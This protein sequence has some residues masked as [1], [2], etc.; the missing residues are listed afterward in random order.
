MKRNQKVLGVA[1]LVVL[2]AAMVLAYATFREKPV[3]GAKSVVIEVVNDV[4]DCVT[5]T[6][7]TDAQYLQ[8]AMDEADGLTYEFEEGPYG[9][10]VYTVNGLRAVYEEDKAYWSF[11]VNG[12]YCNYGISQQP[13]EDGDVF[14]IAYTPAQ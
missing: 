1:A 2:V 4:E 8:Q 5:Y 10:T 7:S 6:L 11:Y 9:A 14:R 3:E 12:G 13:V